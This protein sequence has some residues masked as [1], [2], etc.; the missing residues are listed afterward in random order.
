MEVAKGGDFVPTLIPMSSL[1]IALLMSH[2]F[3]ARAA[4]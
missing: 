3:C 4:S 2:V 1:T